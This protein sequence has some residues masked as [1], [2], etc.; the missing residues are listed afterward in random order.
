MRIAFHLGEID[1]NLID[2]AIFDRVH[3]AGERR[4]EQL[5]VAAI[6]VEIDWQKHAGR[7]QV[8][9]FAQRHAGADAEGARLV[10]GGGDHTAAV[11]LAATADRHRQAAQR[12]A[13]QQLDRRIEGIHVE[14][15]DAAFAQAQA[16]LGG[17]V[18]VSPK[19]TAMAS[20]R[21]SGVAAMS[22]ASASSGASSVSN[23]DRSSD[24]DM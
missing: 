4:L 8:E 20:A 15:G 24:G 2:A 21:A 3:L 1:V 5:R 17:A 13:P 22:S 9:R 14:V 12:R 7:A 18:G 16:A 6:L 10:G 11:R 19:P 23:C